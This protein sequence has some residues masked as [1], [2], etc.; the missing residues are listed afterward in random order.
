MSFINFKFYMP[1]GCF[2]KLITMQNFQK[3][4]ILTI[5]YMKLQKEK[6]FSNEHNFSKRIRIDQIVKSIGEL[7]DNNT[8]DEVI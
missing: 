5:Q 3:H 6:K 7:N 4:I 1:S 2:K 8:T